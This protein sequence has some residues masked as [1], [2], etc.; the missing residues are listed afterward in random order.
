MLTPTGY[1]LPKTAAGMAHSTHSTR[2]NPILGYGCA[3]TPMVRIRIIVVVGDST[4]SLLGLYKI[5]F[6]FESVVHESG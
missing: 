5:F 6:Y 3:H 1:P 2:V 4:H